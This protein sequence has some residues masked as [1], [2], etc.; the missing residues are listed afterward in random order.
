MTKT[1]INEII[2][3]GNVFP[4]SELNEFSNRETVLCIGDGK[5]DVTLELINEKLQEVTFTDNLRIDISVHGGRNEKKQH[6][7]F[8]VKTESF[9]EDLKYILVQHS[10]KQDLAAEWHL[11]SC[12][13]GSSNKA[14][15]ILGK[16]NILIT[17]INSENVSFTNL[18]NYTINR[19]V[20]NYLANP[21]KDAY[22]RWIEEQKYAFQ[23]STF[24]FNPTSDSSDTIHLKN[25]RT[26]KPEILKDIIK[27][28]KSTNDLTEIFTDFIAEDIR[29][30]NKAKELGY[31]KSN[32][33]ESDEV[34]IEVSDEE[35]KNLALGIAI[36]LSGLTKQQNLD[37]FK[38]YIS[39]IQKSGI[40][41]GDT[42]L[43]DESPL[44]IAALQGHQ[45]VVETLLSHGADVNRS[46][47]VGKTPLFSAAKNGY[48]EVVETLLKHGADPNISDKNGVT[49][50]FFAA[51]NGYNEVVETL[52]KHRA[53]PNISH[54]SGVTPLFFAAKNEHS[55]V[56]KTLLKHG[57]NADLKNI[58]YLKKEIDIDTT[59][60]DGSTLL[61][62]AIKDKQSRYN[63]SFIRDRG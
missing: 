54:K 56:I 15:H 25:A 63:K 61:L 37:T 22:T 35:A 16:N 12:Y 42:K 46:S 17:H 47:K 34:R 53:D 4:N 9:L 11:W 38:E 51:Q 7:I 57:A 26:L 52:L 33:K 45:R 62:R 3:I 32:F 41:I 59:A 44:S 21:L 20:E 13:G 58:T 40:D 8:G 2:I 36:Y 5:S 18:D 60:K 1:P 14:A 49:P 55:P 6:R 24:N 30:F 23:P 31:F 29:E 27:K 48:D 39:V 43:F 10:G 50:L 19:S 28:F